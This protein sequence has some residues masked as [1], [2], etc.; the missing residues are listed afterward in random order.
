MAT[1]RP[2]V[3]PRASYHHGDVRGAAIDEG[4]SLLDEGSGSLALR[5]VARRIGVAHHALYHHFADKAAFERALSAKGFEALADRVEGARDA[6]SFVATY[7]RFALDRPRLYELMMRQTYATFESDPELRAGSGRVIAAALDALAPDARDP[8]EGRRIVT[9]SWML[10]HGGLALHATGVLR[11][12]DDEA[13]VAELLRIAGLA[14]DEP[15]GHQPMWADP[16]RSTR[17]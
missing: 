3:P 15:E 10:V 12:R 1:T 11:L 8:E 2:E 7:A 17:P 13:F 4:L 14:P 6:A 9:R 16:P 5:E